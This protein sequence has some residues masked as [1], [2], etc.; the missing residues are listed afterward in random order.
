M[1]IQDMHIEVNQGLQ[2]ISANRTR[3]YFSEE[4]DW[5]LNKVQDRFIQS[6]LST[7]ENGKFERNHLDLDALKNLIKDARLIYFYNNDILSQTNIKGINRYIWLLPD[8]Y[9]YLISSS[10]EVLNLCGGKAPNIIYSDNSFL[11]VNIGKTSATAPPLYIS[12]EIDT[13]LWGNININQ[14]IYPNW[15][16][17]QKVTDN[18]LLIP[19]LLQM[20]RNNPS[21]YPTGDDIVPENVTKG[22]RF[23]KYG[24]HYYP[25]SFIFWGDTSSIQSELGIYY[26]DSPITLQKSLLSGRFASYDIEK[27]TTI[28]AQNRILENEKVISSLQSSYYKT[29]YL[30][31][32]SEVKD[33][34]LYTY[35]D[36]SFII[37]STLIQYIK[38]PRQMSLSLLQNCELSEEFHQL[39]CDLAVEYIQNRITDVES[40]QLKER[41]N[42]QRTIL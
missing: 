18:K 20:L 15:K 35:S 25:N 22:I 33:G 40:Y 1:T 6:K 27:S 36:N 3:K 29:T 41:D 37:N 34:M 8:D 14:G 26:D 39:I 21:T 13:T 10:S 9:A 30:S 11:S 12:V 19:I 42:T 38:K 2:K 28:L 31:P 32:I 7:K 5:V 24:F 4:I 17:Y 16:G 23:E